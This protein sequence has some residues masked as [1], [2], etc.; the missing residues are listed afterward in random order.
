MRENHRISSVWCMVAGNLFRKRN[1][2]RHAGG[3]KPILE[4]NTRIRGKTFPVDGYGFV[5]V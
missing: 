4:Q 5:I 3:V 1:N 2:R